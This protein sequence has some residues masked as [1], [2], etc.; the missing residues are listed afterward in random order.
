MRANDASRLRIALLLVVILIVAVAAL[1]RVGGGQSYSG[2]SSSGGG[3]GSSRSSSG[4]SDSG[5]SYSGSSSGSSSGANYSGGSGG[6]ATCGQIIVFMLF[7]GMVIIFFVVVLRAQAAVRDPVA[8]HTS[9]RASGDRLDAL[10]RFDPNFSRIVFDD[11]CYSLYAR[12]HNARAAGDLARYS[13]YLSVEARR[14]LLARN[15]KGLKE[16]RGI[17]IGSLQVGDLRGLHS[18]TISIPVTYEANFTEIVDAGLGQQESS[19][20]VQEQWWFERRR[21]ILSPP[22]DKAK[23]EHCPRCGAALQTRTDGSCEYCGVTI[24]DGSFQWYVR[25]IV[26][27]TKDAREPLLTSDVPEEGTNLPTV[28]QPD[29]QMRRREFEASHPDFRWDALILRIREIA[30]KL[31]DAWSARD[32]ERIRPLES[33]TLFQSHRYWIDA[34]IRQRLRNIVADYTIKNI[35]PVK[36]DSDAFY[37][38]ITVRLWASGRDYTVDE[39]DKVVAGSQSNIRS[40]SEYWTFF[41]TRGTQAD[42]SKTVSCP[43]CG[44]SV[45]V[46]STGVCRFCGGK[47]A[48]GDFGW[49]L[50][51]IEQDEAYT[52]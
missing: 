41:R 30:M 7:F 38:A 32:W 40:W 20:Y 19:W 50:S 49:V 26:V 14:A 10:G 31:Q 36:V 34:Y 4:S 28:W 47:L 9:T 33:D 46:G 22:P 37:D 12:V 44:A 11:F 51:R 3:G 6:S 13:P 25:N 43:N 1:G 39:S 23:A 2:G 52:G 18:E 8:F 16:V 48:G 42:P 27:V 24:S 29:F 45:E 15:P 17:V 21:D 35:E 5:G